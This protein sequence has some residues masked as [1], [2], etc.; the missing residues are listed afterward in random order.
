MSVYQLAPQQRKC[1]APY[2]DER[3][4]YYPGQE[5]KTH[6]L[7]CY[8]KNVRKCATCQ[9][10]NLKIDAPS[11][12]KQCVSCFIQGRKQ[13]YD[14][15]PRCPPERAHHLRR[16]LDQPMC[17]EC[18]ELYLDQSPPV[19]EKGENKGATLPLACDIPL[20]QER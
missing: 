2:C 8:K 15:C 10:G 3:V 11:W 13:K 12:Q 1:A 5:Y 20:T 17:N 4:I 19:V 14:T 18:A 16:P 7:N 6:C 9:V